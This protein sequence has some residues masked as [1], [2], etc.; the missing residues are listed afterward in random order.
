MSSIF[1]K[2]KSIAENGIEPILEGQKN[3]TLNIASVELK[4]EE[5]SKNC[6]GCVNRVNEPIDFLRIKDERIKPLSEKMCDDCG[7]ALAYLLRQNVKICKHWDN[8]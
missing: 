5:R 1:K 4:A 6:T 7:C 8:D 3:Y 2:I